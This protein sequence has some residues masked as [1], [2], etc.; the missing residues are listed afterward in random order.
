MKV[1]DKIIVGC[2]I[3]LLILLHRYL[4]QAKEGFFDDNS[5]YNSLKE[6]LI[7]EL[8]PYCKISAFVRDQLKT[9]TTATGGS[10]DDA[11]LNKTYKSIYSCTDS[12][13]S[14]R[15]SCS[16]FGG[17]GPNNSMSYVSCDTYTQLPEWSDDGSASL[18]L[19]KIKDDLPERIVREAEWFSAII[20]KL[21]GA[22]AAGANPSMTPPSKEQMDKIVEE[23]KK[24]GFTGTCSVDAAKAQISQKA[25]E[26]A[27]SCTIP[28]ANSEITRVNAVLNSPNLK[29]AIAEM[30]GL[31]TSMLKLQSDLEKAKNGTLYD[32]QKDGPKKSYAQFQGGDRVAAL[33]FSLQQNK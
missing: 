26:E 11:T 25:L 3:L 19:M 16:L 15:Q 6:R 22:L 33:T 31:L 2:L 23:S 29:K 4:F 8:G 18:A 24:D 13:A 7:K 10:G 32:W 21:Q 14:S 9:M 27:A 12:L 28:D 30:D 17:L 1:R 20:N 5:D